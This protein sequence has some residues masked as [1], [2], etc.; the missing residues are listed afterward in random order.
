MLIV[1]NKLINRFS[2]HP[3]KMTSVKKYICIA[4][5]SN[6][7]F[8][9]YHVNNLV[10]FTHYLDNQHQTWRFFNVYS[11]EGINKGTQIASFTKHNR[12]KDKHC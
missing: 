8:V 4:K 3:S 10:R 11:Y 7:K 9:R 1:N 6:D 12:P 5:V 2:H